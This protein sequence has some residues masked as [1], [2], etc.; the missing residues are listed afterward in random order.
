[1]FQIKDDDGVEHKISFVSH[2]CDVKTNKDLQQPDNLQCEQ[3]TD[4]LYV[5]QLNK[6]I[7]YKSGCELRCKGDCDF[8]YVP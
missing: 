8:G 5:H 2:I 3:I 7:P 4:G 1:M 6:Y